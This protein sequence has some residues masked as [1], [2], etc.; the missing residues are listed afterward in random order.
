MTKRTIVTYQD[1]NWRIFSSEK[2]E[3]EARMLML[4]YSRVCHDNGMA[5]PYENRESETQKQLTR[6]RGTLY[7]MQDDA[8]DEALLNRRNEKSDLDG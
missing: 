1:S 6:L 7:Q 4:G 8:I 3:A 5:R 2:S